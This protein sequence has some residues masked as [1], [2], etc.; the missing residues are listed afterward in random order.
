ME[1][2][3]IYIHIPFCVKK[4]SYCDFVS[5]CSDEKIWE[6][7]TNAVVCEIEN[8][9]IENPKKVTT[10]YIGGGTPSLIP[11]NY[12]VKIINTV[13]SRF[14]IEES[15]EITIEVN[16]GT[17]TEKKLVAYKNVG[18]NRISI[19][20]QSAEDR[21][22]KLIGRIHNYQTFLSTYNLTRNIG[23]ENINVDLMLAIPTQT[24]EELLN[25]LNKVI[26]LKPNHISLYSLIVE[27]NTEIKKA[28]EVGKLEYV[29]EKVEREMYWKTK[30]ILEKNGYFHYEISNFAKRGLESKHNMDCWNQEEYIGFGIAAHSYINNKRFSN[31]SNL[32][33]YIKNINEENFEKNIELHE[34]QTKQDKMKEYMIIGLRK[35]GGISISEFERRFRISPLF[36]FRFEIDKLV[37]ENLLEV[38]LDYIKLTKKGLDFANIVFEE[39]I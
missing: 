33:E 14:K 25:T 27:E 9:K 22:L 39:F 6:Q 16:P 3:G 13:K 36:Y 21:I 10:I 11:E 4:C 2:F 35:I 8:K 26:E 1:R 38:D 20:L 24:K 19:G 5:F 17:V 28:L 23:F 12:I 31:I 37:K 32:E 29:D 7:Y 18:I 15:A 34:N 30:R